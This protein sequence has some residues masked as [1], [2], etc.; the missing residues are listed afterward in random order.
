MPTMYIHAITR[1]HVNM[2]AEPKCPQYQ[3]I[4]TLQCTV[5]N[6]ESASY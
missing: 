6:T 4:Q 1:L 2:F 3:Y 5:C